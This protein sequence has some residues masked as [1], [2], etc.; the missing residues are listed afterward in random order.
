M[1]KSLKIWLKLSNSPII[2]HVPKVF[3]NFSVGDGGHF[4]KKLN[5]GGVPLNFYE[6]DRGLKK[7]SVGGGGLE[8]F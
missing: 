5:R 8:K 6:W 2:T 7:F 4:E 1:F 3:Q